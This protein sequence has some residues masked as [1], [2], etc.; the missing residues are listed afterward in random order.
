MYMAYDG[1]DPTCH[2]YVLAGVSPMLSVLD[3]D[4]AVWM[5]EVKDRTLAVTVFE[6]TTRPQGEIDT[7]IYMCM[8]SYMDYTDICCTST[9]IC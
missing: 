8:D 5:A 7:Y 3:E 1:D 6:S 9:C 2:M 4:E